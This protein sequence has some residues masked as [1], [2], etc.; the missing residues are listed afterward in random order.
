MF[1]SS[2]I[3]ESFFYRIQ[4][5]FFNNTVNYIY[6]FALYL[7]FFQQFGKLGPALLIFLLGGILIGLLFS[8]LENPYLNFI[9]NLLP[10]TFTVAG[11]ILRENEITGNYLDFLIIFFV[12]TI[13][14]AILS[15]M[16]HTRRALQRSFSFTL[17]QLNKFLTVISF[18]ILLQSKFGQE[19]TV[20]PR[21][22]S[23]TYKTNVSNIYLLL[24]LL[25]FTISF[26][27][28]MIQL[29]ARNTRLA[30]MSRR[31]KHLSSWS[32]D[33]RFIEENLTSGENYLNHE[34]RT[35]IIGDIRGFSAFSESNDIA[36]VVTILENL[37]SV[38][39]SVIAKYRGFKPEFIADEFITFFDSN[40]DAINCALEL[41]DQVNTYLDQFDLGLGMGIDRG[42]VLE[43]VLGGSES[44]KYTVIGRAVNISSRLQAYAEK[45][46]I[47]VTRRAIQGI[48]GL[49]IKEIRNLKLKGVNRKFEVFSLLAIGEEEKKRHPLQKLFG[50]VKIKMKSISLK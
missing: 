19:L 49:K 6:I 25:V 18:L 41:S 11:F 48:N 34:L 46:Q 17:M 3:E 9:A 1:G 32:L 37:Y 13:T 21:F 29:L 2:K 16:M 15:G 36:T 43:G 42:P 5:E 8:T 44:K 27:A 33:R 39:E 22:L 7:F 26:F 20:T 35:I 14:N 28:I 40:K 30:N 23:F 12:Y 50:G 24:N 47:L 38:V 31:L 4:W 45:K 10:F